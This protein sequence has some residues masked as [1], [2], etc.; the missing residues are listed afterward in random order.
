MKEKDYR[1][2]CCAGPYEKDEDDEEEEGEENEEVNCIYAENIV[3][4]LRKLKS[5]DGD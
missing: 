4:L 5:E 3:G 2:I 1:I